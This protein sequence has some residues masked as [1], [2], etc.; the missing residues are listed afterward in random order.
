MAMWFALA[1]HYTTLCSQI[2]ESKLSFLSE[3]LYV[4]VL[5]YKNNF[6]ILTFSNMCV[7]VIR[8]LSCAWGGGKV[9]VMHTFV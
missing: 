3:I 8:Y 6:C 9:S 4:D 1:G 2:H 7:V 5:C